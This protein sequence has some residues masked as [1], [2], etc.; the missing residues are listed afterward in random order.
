MKIGNKLHLLLELYRH[1]GDSVLISKDKIPQ[2]KD[3]VNY[4]FIT[5]IHFMDF[6]LSWD[7]QGK[8]LLEQAVQITECANNNAS[9]DFVVIGG[10]SVQ[11][12]WD[13]KDGWKTAIS[14]IMKPFTACQKPVF[15]LM[16]NH[17]DNTYATWNVNYSEKVISDLDWKNCVLDPVC[18]A[19]IVRPADDPNAKHYYYDFVK[20]GKTTRLFFLDAA[21]YYQ[22]YD[23]NGTITA[24]QIREGYTEDSEETYDKYHHGRSVFGYSGVQVKWLADSLAEADKFDDVI[25]F[26]HMG[27]DAATSIATFGTEVAAVM[28]AYNNKTAYKNDELGIDVSYNDD[29]RIL[30]YQFGH[31]HREFSGYNSEANLWQI[32]TSTARA[33]QAQKEANRTLGNENETCFDIMSVSKS[34]IHKFNIGAGEDG[35]YMSNT[36]VTLTNT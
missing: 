33:D 6:D 29:G 22:E 30:V 17:D 26:S 24:L 15:V 20:N 28:A 34:A 9:I 21:D 2:N 36:N 31:I 16:G 14:N 35:L 27:T 23:E 32:A 8:V 4:I 7:A 1:K 3:A 5:D 13:T 12:F 18:P 19:N 11:G 25:I 10:D